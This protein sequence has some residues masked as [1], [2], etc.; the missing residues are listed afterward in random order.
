MFVSGKL[1]FDLFKYNLFDCMFALYDLLQ[2][3]ET[4]NRL[5]HSILEMKGCIAAQHIK[6]PPHCARFLYMYVNT[7][8]NQFIFKSKEKFP[9]EYVS[10]FCGSFMLF[11]SCFCNAIGA[12][13]GQLLGKC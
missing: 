4:E 12:L 3:V 9:V 10:A 7:L 13:Y 11:L 1:L 8:A 5:C 6:K 2:H